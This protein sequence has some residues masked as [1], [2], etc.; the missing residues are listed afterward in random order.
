[1]MPEGGEATPTQIHN[2]K[3]RPTLAENFRGTL[4]YNT[5]GNIVQTKTGEQC[6]SPVKKY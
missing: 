1:V 2:S 5:K 6:R 4:P 3:A